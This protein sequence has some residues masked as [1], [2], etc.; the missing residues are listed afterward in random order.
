MHPDWRVFGY[1]TVLVA[2]ATVAS[3]MA[4][5][6]A[7]LKLDL[8]TALKGRESTATMRSRLTGSLIVAQIAMSFV[9]LAAA[10]MF[11]RLPRLVTSMDPGFETHQILS[12]PV[13]YDTAP[14]N[15]T[16]ALGFLRAVEAHLREV[17]GVQ[18][19]AWQSLA[20]FNQ[21][22]PSEIRLPNQQKGQGK[23]ATVDAVSSEFFSTF[24]VRMLSGRSFIPSDPTLANA[25]SVAVVSQ[26]FAKEFWPDQD[27]LGKIVLTSDDKRCVVIGVAADTRSERFGV[28]DG[29]RLYTLRDPAALDGQ[30][31]L[32]FTGSAK[33]IETAVFDAVRSL[34]RTQVTTPETLWEAL[35]SDAEDIRSLANIVV[36]MASIAVLLAVT[37]VYGVLSFA[38]SQRTRELGVRIVLGANRPAI[39]RSILVRGARQIAI[40]LVCG[41]VLT[42]PAAWSFAR[43]LKNSHFPFRTFDPSVYSIAGALLLAVSLIAMILPA[44]R[45]TKVDPITALRTD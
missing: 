12:V 42:E 11:A 18:S 7:A 41:V 38:I 28:L 10:V 45:A 13:G 43:L 14:Q 5:M 1:L 25:G 15:R 37:G 27:P 31:Y 40:G 22:P 44:L 4:P 36:S 6:H 3:S 23:P 34:D 26:A 21:A 29:P 35:E 20:P 33:A 17:P 2:L 39:F 9:L 24:G 16:A 32:R 30:L 8:I 19:L